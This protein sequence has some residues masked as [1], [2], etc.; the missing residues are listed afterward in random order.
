MALEYLKQIWFLSLVAAHRVLIEKK[1][2]KKNK[3]KAC[4][5]TELIRVQLANV[6]RTK[7]KYQVA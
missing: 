3:H 1:K 6:T 5:D 4:V 2:R 7:F